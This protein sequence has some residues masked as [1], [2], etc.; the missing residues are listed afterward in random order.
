[1]DLKTLRY[2]EAIAQHGS[3]TKAAGALHVVQPVLSVAI[4]RLEQ[5]LGVT[6][7]SRESRRVMPTAEGRLLL[8]HASRIFQEL[9]SLKRELRD[10]SELLAGDITVGLPPM[11]GMTFFP[12]TIAAFNAAYPGV[13]INAIEGSADEI[14]RLLDNGVLDLAVLE[15]RRVRH[16]WKSVVIGQDEMVLAVGV[17]HPLAQRRTVD[18]GA[19]DALPVVV[20]DTTFLQRELLDRL[21]RKGKAKYRVVMQSNFVYMI[22]RAIADGVGAGTLLRGVAAMD[23]RLVPLSFSPKQILKFCLCWRDDRHVSKANR[24][25]VD[26]ATTLASHP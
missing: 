20:F 7:F 18:A 17:S 4:K 13:T 9:D 12:P 2:V 21:C 5:D 14:A 15:R 8:A 11:F 16:A 1:M 3:F 22:M 23:P 19:L 6:L 10:T 25:F 24:A 26:L